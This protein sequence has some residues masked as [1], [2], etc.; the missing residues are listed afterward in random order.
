MSAWA[1]IVNHDGSDE[2]LELCSEALTEVQC[3]IAHRLAEKIREDA[4]WDEVNGEKWRNIEGKR[5]AADLIDPE[6][7]T[8]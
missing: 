8:K 2:W 6:K 7:E 3:E 1:E 4:A 5:D